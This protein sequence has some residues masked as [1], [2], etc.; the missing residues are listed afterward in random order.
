MRTL[1]AAS[2]LLLVS[3]CASSGTPRPTEDSA[4]RQ[5]SAR[6]SDASSG[7]VPVREGESSAPHRDHPLAGRIWDVKGNRFVDEAELLRALA[8]ARF[9]V[10]GE[11]HDQADHHQ[12]QAKLVRALAS[13]A[14]KPALAFEMLDVE[15][16]PAVDASLARAPEDTEALA[17]A[18]RWADSGWPP[19]SLYQPVFAAGLERGLPIVAAN[20][21]RTQVRELVKRGPEALPP[22]LRERLALDTPLPEDVARQMREEQDRAHCGH[23]PPALLGP[24]AEAQRARDAHLADRLLEADRGDGGVLITGNGHARTDRGAPAHLARRAP[25]KQVVS[26]GLLEV[27]PEAPAP[28]DYAASYS[29]STLPFDYVWFTPAQ[30]QEDPCAPLRERKR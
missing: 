25:D 11:R 17:Q 29:A 16:Q 7:A 30:P 24:M 19:F 6:P 27:S 12:R 3:A 28:G 14:R 4:S 8:G 15:Q 5:G 20:L 9:V 13:G 23:L 2:V 10:L 26:V 1:L 21:P 22:A 18:V